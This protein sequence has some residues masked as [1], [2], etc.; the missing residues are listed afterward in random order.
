MKKIIAIAAI[1]ASTN[2][3]AFFSDNNDAQGQFINNGNADV[4]GNATGEGEAT[5]GITFE[6]SGTTHGLMTGNG[7]NNG[8]IVARGDDARDNGSATGFADNTANGRGEGQGSGSAKFSMTF[9]GRAK[10]AGDFKG[11]G[12]MDSNNGFNSV[13]TPY[14]YTPAK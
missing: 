1:V 7:S 12:N 6:G 13:S 3:F 9:S 5:F 14:Y 11:N 8:N 2:S 10:S 4:V